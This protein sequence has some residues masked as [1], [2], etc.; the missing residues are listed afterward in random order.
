MTCAP[1]EALW[2]VDEQA[3]DI[4]SPFLLTVV[5]NALGRDGKLSRMALRS[6]S[7]ED[8][9]KFEHV[10][11]KFLP[12]KKEI[13]EVLIWDL[14]KTVYLTEGRKRPLG[15]AQKLYK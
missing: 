7:K 14:Y 10:Y 12:N 5:S 13:I 1:R 2:A 4:R 15:S 11:R 6:G 8:R 3:L 9:E